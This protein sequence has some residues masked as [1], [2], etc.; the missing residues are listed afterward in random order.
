[1]H[2]DT[3]DLQH[4]A[5]PAASA[6]PQPSQAPEAPAKPSPLQPAVDGTLPCPECGS[7]VEP[8]SKNG[9]ILFYG[10]TAYRKTGCRGMW[11]AD[12]DNGGKPFVKICPE[13]GKALVKRR[14]KKGGKSYVACFNA[15]KHKSGEVLFF[16]AEGEPEAPKP[17]PKGEFVCPE[18]G[19][20]LKYFKLKKGRS[21]GSMCFAC[22]ENN[23]HANC[24]PR[25]FDDADGVPVF[26]KAG[27]ESRA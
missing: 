15:Q 1:M 4:S 16:D 2:N 27:A 25:F 17:R 20:P 8:I 18:C 21:A 26:D 7:P 24:Q 9:V 22:F 3:A 14:S 23:R 19:G 13:C 10:C 11:S 12:P 6:A 5:N